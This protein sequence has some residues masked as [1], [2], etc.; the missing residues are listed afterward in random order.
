MDRGCSVLLLPLQVG[1]SWRRRWQYWVL[2]LL[3]VL[4][5]SG[6][7]SL[8]ERLRGHPYWSCAAAWMTFAIVFRLCTAAVLKGNAQQRV[9]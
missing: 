8:G 3:A 4:V 9:P 1:A 5:A 6:G 7:V 2:L